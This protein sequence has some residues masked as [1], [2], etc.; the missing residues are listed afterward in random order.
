MKK[1]PGSLIS[2]QRTCIYIT[3]NVITSFCVQFAENFL[4]FLHYMNRQNYILNYHQPMKL[5][6]VQIRNICNLDN[7]LSKFMLHEICRNI[8]FE[9]MNFFNN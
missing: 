8:K 2:I 6:F 5:N 4:M 7:C 1:D 9:N 3:R